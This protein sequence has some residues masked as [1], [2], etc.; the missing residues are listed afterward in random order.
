VVKEFSAVAS[1]QIIEA[2]S[3]SSNIRARGIFDR[4]ISKTQGPG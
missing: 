4:I 1:Q 2:A 3:L